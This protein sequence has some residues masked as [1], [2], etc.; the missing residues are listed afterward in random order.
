MT[1][2]AVISHPLFIAAVA[3]ILGVAASIAGG[4]LGGILVGAKSLGRDLAAT[5]GSIYG[6]LAGFTGVALGLVVLALIH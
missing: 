1:I 6:P 2:E 4:I 3:L 5:M